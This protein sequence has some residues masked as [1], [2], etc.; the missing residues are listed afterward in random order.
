M[1]DMVDNLAIFQF[2]LKVPP[3]ERAGIEP[4]TQ[5]VGTI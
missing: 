2:I 5:R 4:I 1:V 3:R